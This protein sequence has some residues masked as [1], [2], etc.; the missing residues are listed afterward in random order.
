M[1]LHVGL[2]L[3]NSVDIFVFVN[4]VNDFFVLV[5]YTFY[6]NKLF[7]FKTNLFVHSACIYS[8]SQVF[9]TFFFFPQK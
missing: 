9:L 1:C 2:L 4:S 7:I 6:I 8:V 3:S 5:I